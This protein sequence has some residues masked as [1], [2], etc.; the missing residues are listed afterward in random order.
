METHLI[1]KTKMQGTILM[2]FWKRWMRMIRYESRLSDAERNQLLKEFEEIGIVDTPT[3]F[4]ELMMP[5][6]ADQC[7]QTES[8]R[9]QV[10]HDKKSMR[11]GYL[12]AKNVRLQIRK[13]EKGQSW[14]LRSI[15]MSP[16]SL[17]SSAA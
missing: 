12:D 9:S 1:Q 16:T 13:A 2:I 11:N 10:G 7:A 6:A 15:K 4:S 14:L 3:V 5:Q 17:Q 8:Q